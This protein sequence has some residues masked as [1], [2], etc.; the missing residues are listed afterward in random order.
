MPIYHSL[1]IMK[2]LGKQK[3]IFLISYFIF[4]CYRINRQ[5]GV[6]T[7]GKPLDREKQSSYT[8]KV[9]VQD[10]G[11]PPLSTD[12]LL[13]IIIDDGKLNISK[14]CINNVITNKLYDKNFTML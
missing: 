11:I 2:I 10:N 7:V 9:T 6:I 8:L 4:I 12:T 14:T 13:E 1:L 5:T 3:N